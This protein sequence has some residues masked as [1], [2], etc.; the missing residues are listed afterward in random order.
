[1][2]P[3]PDFFAGAELNFAKNLLYPQI[4]EEFAPIKDDDIAIIEANEVGSRN[5]TWAGLRVEVRKCANGL[6]GLGLKPGDRVAGFLG[7]HS[8]TVVAMLAA[9]SLGG[10]VSASDDF[11]DPRFSDQSSL[12][13]YEVDRDQSRHWCYRSLGQ[14]GSDRTKGSVCR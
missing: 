9:S 8:M 13:M 3:R 11:W 1:M 2:F 6:R 4:A 5:V 7:N 14:T 12:T 10:I